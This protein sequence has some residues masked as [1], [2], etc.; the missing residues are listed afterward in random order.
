MINDLFQAADDAGVTLLQGKW[1]K[2]K[3]IWDFGYQEGIKIMPFGQEPRS[4][5]PAIEK[6]E[7]WLKNK[8]VMHDGNPVM[9]FCISNAVVKEVDD[10]RRLSK[11]LSTGR[12]D[13]A[14]SSVMACG[15]ADVNKEPQE[16]V[17]ATRGVL[18]FGRI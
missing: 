18:T 13:G 3:K 2:E 1:D 12:I 10:Y 5:H 4:M 6:F 16:S 14:V 8:E 9:T 15:V 11:S 17:Y 7:G